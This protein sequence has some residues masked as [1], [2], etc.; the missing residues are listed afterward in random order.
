MC[1][2]VFLGVCAVLPRV[3]A[4]VDGQGGTTS[5]PN[6]PPP[7]VTVALKVLKRNETEV[8]DGRQGMAV[9][10]MDEGGSRE[11]R[12]LVWGSGSPPV[13]TPPSAPSS[14]TPDTPSR[15][16]P[17]PIVTVAS[18]LL[19]TPNRKERERERESTS[20]STRN[21]FVGDIPM[22]QIEFDPVPEGDVYRTDKTHAQSSVLAW[23]G[24]FVSL[25]QPSSVPLG[26]C[27]LIAFPPTHTLVLYLQPNST[28][29]F[30]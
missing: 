25:L 24:S 20:G 27:L 3:T 18:R 9:L 29:T 4:E 7:Q 19:Y 13:H 26:G 5:T 8:G 10:G 14:P 6:D 23:A 17:L 2:A 16:L 12:S 1:L 15:R 22:H 28:L 30:S 11:N 21:A